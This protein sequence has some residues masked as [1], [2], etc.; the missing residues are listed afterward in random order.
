MRNFIAGI[1]IGAGAILP[2]ISS[3]VLYALFGLYEK[4]VNSVLNFFKDIKEFYISIS[5]LFRS[6]CWCFFVWK[7]SKS[8]F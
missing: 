6:F 8:S 2:G 5:Y 1:F 4:L 3:G 7:Y